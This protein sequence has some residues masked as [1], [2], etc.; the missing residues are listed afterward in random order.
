[1]GSVR[2]GTL[3]SSSMV[4]AIF[5]WPDSAGFGSADGLGASEVVG[6]AE[7]LGVSPV[8]VVC[9]AFAPGSDASA[10]ASSVGAFLAGPSSPRLG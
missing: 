7:A 10:D 9:G 1:M 4:L 5:G 3:E 2:T 6:E 8:F